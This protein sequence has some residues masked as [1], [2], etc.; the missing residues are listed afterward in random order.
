[1]STSCCGWRPVRAAFD[2]VRR[3]AAR[4]GLRGR[5]RVWQRWTGT[6]YSMAGEVLPRS[7]VILDLGCG[8]GMLA[9]LLAVHAPGRELVGL[10]VDEAKVGRARRLFGDL[11]RF[12]CVDF[13]NPLEG[14]L[15]ADAVVIWDVLHHLAE[16]AALLRWARSQL[17]P[18]GLLLVKENDVEPLTKRLI[19]E[20]VEVVA[21]GLDVT[22]SAPVRFRSRAEWSRMLEDAGFRVERSEHLRAREGFFVPH[23][24]FV[25]R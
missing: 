16:P 19:A 1:M 3:R 2:E 8:F 21:V 24:V 9:A 11:A 25:A 6:P 14:E 10:D 23:S 15:R 22:A 4:D 20:A 5:L 12:E 13:S 17:R 18:G 7:G